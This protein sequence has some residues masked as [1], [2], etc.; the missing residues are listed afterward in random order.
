M[1]QQ[2]GKPGKTNVLISMAKKYFS[3][4]ACVPHSER[5]FLHKSGAIAW[6]HLTFKKSEQA[7]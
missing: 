6:A 7:L 5:D 1:L 3:S 2:K 4:I